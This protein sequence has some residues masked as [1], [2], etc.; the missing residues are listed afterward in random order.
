[1]THASDSA[2]QREA[3]A[4]ILKA[5]SEQLGSLLEP[6]RVDLPGGTWSKSTE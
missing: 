3:E 6:R 2:V 5:I 4:V 1:V